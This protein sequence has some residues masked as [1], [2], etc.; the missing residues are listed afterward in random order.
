[1]ESEVGVTD[2]KYDDTIDAF[3]EHEV[4]KKLAAAREDQLFPDEVDTPQVTKHLTAVFI[5]LILLPYFLP[6][7][8]HSQP[9]N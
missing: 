2:E 8:P 4:L 5:L 1:M 7:S 6:R 3:E 9:G